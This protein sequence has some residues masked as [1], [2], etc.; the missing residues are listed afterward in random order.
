MSTPRAELLGERTPQAGSSEWKR[1]RD[2][3][4]VDKILDAGAGAAT[5]M[6]TRVGLNITR[7]RWRISR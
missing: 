5:G 1:R 3:D 7:R 6:G 2:Q 4:Q